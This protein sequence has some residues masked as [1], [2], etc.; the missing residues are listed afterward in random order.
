MKRSYK[1][2]G[3]FSILIFLLLSNLFAAPS[4]AI[5][6]NKLGE[7][8]D[9]KMA[10]QGVTVTAEG[11]RLTCPLQR[12]EAYI[13]PTGSIIRSVSETEGRGDFSITPV[14][15]G[16]TNKTS[17]VPA[18]GTVA[19]QDN[20]SI[21]LDRELMAE[22]FSSNSDGIRQDFIIARR[23]A[24]KG[25]MS[26][27]LLIKGA[28][29]ADGNNGIALAI[30]AGRKF[31]YGNLK[32][33]DA[34][35]K[36]L[37]A[38]MVTVSGNKLKITVNDIGAKYP[39]TIDPTIT[40]ADWVSMVGYSAGTNGEVHS[41]IYNKGFLYVGG[42]FTT[43]GNIVARGVAKW[44]G[45]SWRALGSGVNSNV[46]ALAFDS[47][48]NLYVGGYFDSAGG[49]VVNHVAMWNGNSW[50]A[51]GSGLNGFWQCNALTCD[52]NGNLY[53]A[54]WFDTAGG[55][56]VNHIAKWDGNKWDS[57]GPG[58]GGIIHALVIDSSDNLYAGASA[59]QKW[60]GSTWNVLDSGF[61]Y[62]SSS[63]GVLALTF[64]RHWTLYASGSYN[65]GY[66]S[67]NYMIKWN[68][69]RWNIIGYGTISAYDHNYLWWAN[70]YSL[71]CDSS[72]NLYAGGG[73]TT[74]N[75]S[76]VYN[77]GS[78]NPIIAKWDGANWSYFSYVNGYIYT[79]AF[80]DNG[81]LYTGG[82]FTMV[83]DNLAAQHIAKY[84]DITH[85]TT[86]GTGVNGKVNAVI[87]S[88]NGNLFVGGNFTTIGAGIPANR[89]VKWDG[90]AWSA[91]GNGMDSTVQALAVDRSGN[92][93]AGG[94]FTVAG[95]TAANRVAKWNGSAWSAL[96]VGTSGDV[97]ALAVDRSGN[98]YAGGLFGTAG[99]V[100]ARNIAKWNGS[101]WGSLGTGANNYVFSLTCD[102]SGNLYAGG[103]F[104]TAGGVAAKGVA[105]WNGSTWDSLGSGINF[106]TVIAFDGRGN[107]YS[108]APFITGGSVTEKGIAKWN[109]STW[110]SLGSGIMGGV[111][112]I[113]FD[114]NGN[115]Y[116]GGLFDTAG[117]IAANRIAKWDGNSWSALGSGVNNDVTTLVVSDS[118]LFVGGYFDTAGL[119]I[120]PSIAKVNLNGTGVIFSKPMLSAFP[121]IRYHIRNSVLYISNI[122]SR[123]RICLYSLS[124][125]CLREAEG[126]SVMKLQGIASQPL[127]IRVKRSNKIVSTGMVMV[128]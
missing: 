58:I 97:E 89:I 122:S 12:L 39:V 5:P 90:S 44:D 112:A 114:G 102:S 3:I 40:D 79:L 74:I 77:A 62:L 31:I 16:R 87:L 92:L 35:G 69:S 128:Q 120:S 32:A 65:T 25:A 51:L 37:E 48:G 101:S 1:S 47:S 76:Y 55:I 98:L 96:G 27:S 119:K 18:V 103:Y 82:A 15:L 107:L 54:G 26:L 45:S 81:N 91:L 29:A 38:T 71:A 75:G 9:K 83:N 116:A 28:Q 104:A 80:D 41:I 125:C 13:S 95:N 84:N 100:S 60:N 6:L 17:N 8:A 66:D 72:G 30:P 85:W 49:I 73:F 118:T 67:A 46:S 115:L 50:T 14:I 124:G 127:I 94:V 57:L 108:S 106:V 10:S 93:Y 99:G 111:H 11:L 33:T 21:M 53:A 19:T 4:P 110:D 34:I 43:T 63:Q 2:S 68:G 42:Y 56:V 121:A 59:V 23:P 88:N 113:A 24:G 126:V 20:R 78:P 22:Q 117:G 64:D 109:G 70:I 123:D 36:T 86:L 7:E 105:K 52:R 61:P